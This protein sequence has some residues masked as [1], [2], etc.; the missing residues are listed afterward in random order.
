MRE[1]GR[2]IL[3]DVLAQPQP[4]ARR[5]AREHTGKRGL[6]HVERVAPQVVA[7]ELIRSKGMEEHA[8]VMVLVPDA[9]EGRDPI[10]T[11]RHS[12]PVDDAGPRPP[13]RGRRWWRQR[14]ARRAGTMFFGRDQPVSCFSPEKTSD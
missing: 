13:R 14:S 7:V 1:H 10:V 4:Q 12:L 5:S 8:A 6:P 2:A 9:I 11:A 3:L